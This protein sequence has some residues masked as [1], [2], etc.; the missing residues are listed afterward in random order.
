[1]EILIDSIEKFINGNTSLPEKG[2]VKIPVSKDRFNFNIILQTARC[3]I[4]R[5]ATIPINEAVE[6]FFENIPIIFKSVVV[7]IDLL[8]YY[9][10][11]LKD[12]NGEDNV[13][14]VYL[15]MINQLKVGD[16]ILFNTGKKGQI[17][18]F[19]ESTDGQLRYRLIKKDGS[20]GVKCLCLY[21]ISEKY[22]YKNTNREFKDYSYLKLK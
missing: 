8:E 13:F 6:I 7:P 14:Y 17:L 16:I 10:S 22:Q 20:L 11:L 15:L 18:H 1:M 12:C 9:L 5:G 2:Y 4:I 21:A 3:E 19:K